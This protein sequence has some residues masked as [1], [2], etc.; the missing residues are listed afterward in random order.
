MYILL[1]G[2]FSVIA[3]LLAEPFFYYSFSFEWVFHLLTG[4]R[5]NPDTLVALVVGV[6]FLVLL[7]FYFRFVFGY[8]IRNFERQADLY[9]FKM[10]GS[11][12]ALVSAFDKIA[13]TSGQSRKKPNWH[14]FGIGERIDTLESV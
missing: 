8:F 4:E 3:G 9:V 1:I 12:R 5:I 13:E 6:P 14:H 7:L 2:G 10:L 11:I